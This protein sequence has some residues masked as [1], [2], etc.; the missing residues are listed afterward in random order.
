MIPYTHPSVYVT[1]NGNTAC[2]VYQI[3]DTTGLKEWI[4][5]I[6]VK[7]STL[8]NPE[9]NTYNTNAAQ[10]VS[11]LLDIVGKTAGYDYIRVYEDETKTVPWSTDANGYIPCFK[12]SDYTTDSLEQE[13]DFN[14]LQ[15]DG[16][17]ILLES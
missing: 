10:L 11:N 4:D 9:V 14:L 6:P 5:Y 3:T 1:Y 16:Y 2:V 8:D 17:L 7:F 15:E 13:N 12:V